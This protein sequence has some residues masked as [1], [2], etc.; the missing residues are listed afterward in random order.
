MARKRYGITKE[1]AK[2]RGVPVLLAD[3]LVARVIAESCGG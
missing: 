3:L 2:G 1:A